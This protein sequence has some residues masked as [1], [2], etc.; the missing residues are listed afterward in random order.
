MD[1]EEYN[2][3]I[4]DS[5]K[6]INKIKILCNFFN[7][8]ILFNINTRI[9]VIHQLFVNNKE[10]DI[11]KLDIFH[12]QFTVTIIDLLGNIKKIKEQNI[13]LLESEVRII[14]EKIS[15][16]NAIPN[17]DELFKNEQKIHSKNMRICLNNIY[18]CLSN[19][20][21]D[22]C[23]ENSNIT[24]FNIKYSNNY[25]NIDSNTFKQINNIDY[26]ICYTDNDIII[27]K[28][29][30]GVLNKYNYDIS[31]IVGLKCGLL[32]LEIFKINTTNEYFVFDLSKK[33]FIFV[34]YNL[35]K[36]HLTVDNTV[37]FRNKLDLINKCN[38]LSFKINDIR[39]Q[40]P[41]N[42]MLVLSDVLIKLNDV[43]FLK[44]MEKVDLQTAILRDLLNVEI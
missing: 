31:F 40:L 28:K 21:K 23:I 39:S 15:E 7:Q 29:L 4:K 32:I 5:D 12:A 26:N 43:D 13:L 30:L 38:D 19:S 41:E 44:D 8:N 17:N 3:I 14:N 10:L 6:K 16:I 11:F 20:K 27:Q 22:K 34:D 2:R 1:V 24:K 33:L 35:I 25:I 18:I 42:V 37:E 36:N 9:Q